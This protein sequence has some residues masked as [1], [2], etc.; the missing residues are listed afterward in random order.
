MRTAATESTVLGP[1]HVSGAPERELG[2][3]ICLDGEGMPIVV[4]GRMTDT[5]GSPI[6]G[7]Q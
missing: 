1:F 7:L 2:D 5:G 6:G 4:S 3:N